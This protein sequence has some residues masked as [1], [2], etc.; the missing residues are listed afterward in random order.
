[1][2]PSHDAIL[3]LGSNLGHGPATIR[4][5]LD[6]LA[7]AGADMIRVSSMYLTSPVGPRDQPDFTNAAAHIRTALAHYWP[8]ANK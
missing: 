2:S 4:A 3:G 1:M 5:A 8:Y 6:A 7:R